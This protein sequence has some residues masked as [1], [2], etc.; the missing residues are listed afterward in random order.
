MLKGLTE[1]AFVPTGQFP[2]EK[3]LPEL[4]DNHLDFQIGRALLAF[5]E[6]HIDDEDYEEFAKKLIAIVPGLLD[7]GNFVLLLDIV[8][9]LF[10]HSREKASARVRLVAEDAQKAFRDPELMAKAVSA[11]DVWRTAGKEA[12]EFLYTLGPGIVPGLLDIF[13]HDESPGG[14][15]TLFD[16]LCKFG[17][18][19]VQEAHKR[20]RDPRAHYVRNLAML[21]RWAGTPASV[22]HLKPL[23]HHPDRKVRMEGL[24]ALLKFKDLG[25]LAVL[26]DSFRS[27]DP[28]EVS[29]A[30]HLA[31]QHRVTAV[32]NDLLAKMKKV[33]LFET[34]YIVNEEIIRALGEIGDPRA[35]PELEK[36]VRMQLTLYPNSRDRMKVTLFES[37]ERYPRESITGLLR[38]GERSDNDRIRLVCR[39]LME[40]K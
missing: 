3:Y 4:E 28:D 10:R 33:I 32:V 35:I 23:L 2:V 20:L 1:G 6:E 19:S 25:A 36:L 15:R 18:L 7:T 5:M 34:D 21:I 38:I 24:T 30:V 37:L 31:G 22:P 12:A 16:L 9:T 11:F 40:R 27:E 13:A 29:H 26:R 8:Q 39:K 17:Q 14:R